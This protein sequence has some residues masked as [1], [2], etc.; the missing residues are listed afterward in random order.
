M[1][2]PSNNDPSD[3]PSLEH[4]PIK[5][6]TADAKSPLQPRFPDGSLADDLLTPATT[7]RVMASNPPQVEP[8]TGAEIEELP[9]ASVE[10]ISDGNDSDGNDRPIRAEEDDG[11]GDLGLS[12]DAL[13]IRTGEIPI[14]D[15]TRRR[16]RSLEPDEVLRFERNDPEPPV[17][18]SAH[19]QWE[20]AQ[21]VLADMK[22][23][24]QATE[25]GSWRTSTPPPKPLAPIP[26]PADADSGSGID[27][28][29]EQFFD[30]NEPPDEPEESGEEISMTRNNWLIGGGIALGLIVCVVLCGG[31]L[32]GT[33]GGLAW[34]GLSGPPD[35][36]AK[37]SVPTFPQPMP[38]GPV[39]IESPQ[40]VDQPPSTISPTVAIITTTDDEPIW[41]VCAPVDIDGKPSIVYENGRMRYFED[42][43]NRVSVLRRENMRIRG[44][45]P[46]PVC[47]SGPDKD[48]ERVDG[49]QLNDDGQCLVDSTDDGVDNATVDQSLTVRWLC[50]DANGK[51]VS[52]DMVEKNLSNTYAPVDSL[53]GVTAK[54]CP[55]SVDNACKLSPPK[56]EAKDK[57]ASK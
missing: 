11:E 2:P 42:L 26:D 22:A 3:A 51:L 12:E 49:A 54:C 48:F 6:H 32:V 1:A 47:T 21:K 50:S 34:L 31:G 7:P 33:T 56:A 25:P 57:V 41:L 5:A 53:S 27:Q 30:D 24:E 4:V 28:L 10:P 29:A 39:V 19:R 37:G 36:V 8:H 55:G 43:E 15:T 35:T 20:K 18:S 46:R 40:S 44:L 17:G 52:A 38:A 9:D 23:R 16:T 14:P 45:N 13:V